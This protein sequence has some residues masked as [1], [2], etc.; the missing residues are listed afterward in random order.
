[1]FCLSLCSA[2][3]SEIRERVGTVKHVKPS[4][5]FL[6]P[7]F[8][9]DPFCNFCFDCVCYTVL[10]VPLSFLIICWEKAELLAL[11]YVI[12]FLCF[13][14]FSC[15]YLNESNAHVIIIL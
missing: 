10:S 3:I 7:V 14:T 1:M 4:S 8:Y 11:M 6:L 13:V 12:V 2:S 15:A 5:N 9:V